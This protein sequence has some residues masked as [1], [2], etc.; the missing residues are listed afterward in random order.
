[1]PT[2]NDLYMKVM[3][4]A[5]RRGYIWGPSP[6]IYGGLSGF[7]DIGPLGKGLKTN[8]ETLLRKWLMKNNFWEIE[9]NTISPINVWI[10]SGHVEGFVDPIVECKKCGS[11]YRADKLIEEFRPHIKTFGLKFDELS[12]IIKQE[13]IRCPK[14]K[15]E[16]SEVRE[17]NLMLR[18]TV[19]LDND[20][21]LRPET[22]TTTYV[23]FNR[24][25]TFFR[26]KLPIY[27]FQMGRAYRNEISPRQGVLRLREFTQVEAQ[28]FILPEQ[29]NN[30]RYFDEI[31]DYELPV[32]PYKLQESSNK[33]DFVYMKI[34]E[35]LRD[36]HIEN[37]AFGWHLWVGFKFYEFLNIPKGSIRI[38]QHV[39]E[40]R[41]H[42][43]RD[44]W[45]IEVMTQRFGWV[46]V[47]GI[48][49]RGDYDLSRHQEFSKQRLSVRLQ[50]GSYVVPHVLEIAYGIERTLYVILEYAYREDEKRI[51]LQLPRFLAPIQVGVFPLMKKDRLPERA[52][53]IYNKI[54]DKGF[55]VIYD[56][57]GSIGRRYRRMDEVGTPFEITIDYQTLEDDTVTIRDRDTMKQIRVNED[58]IIS[59]LEKH[60]AFPI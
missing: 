21:I 7:Y 58:E 1:M 11:I 44:A 39:P 50:D 32:L 41:A 9:S 42:Y 5:K 53:K 12:K 3:T 19:G 23:L 38:R 54:R 22:A 55:F 45:D 26:E 27:V 15:G 56:E 46:E 49:D 51:W 48:H 2:K 59:Y 33:E 8:I 35:L 30:F 43:A 52:K 13:N 34:N 36:G 4:L 20:C 18:T 57:D 29:K 10:A 47:C 24:L 40:E 28:T 17:Y 16:L 25:F 14:C 6:E 37:P 60:L 31:K